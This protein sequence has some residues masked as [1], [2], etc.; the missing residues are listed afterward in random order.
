VAEIGVVAVR[1][2]EDCMAGQFLIRQ[3]KDQHP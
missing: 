3:T 2:L 1:L